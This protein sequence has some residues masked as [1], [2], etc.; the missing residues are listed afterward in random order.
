MKDCNLFSLCTH[1]EWPQPRKY[2]SS[3]AAKQEKKSNIMYRGDYGRTCLQQA[4]C[5]GAPD[6]IIKTMI[7]IG[8]KELV[9]K[10]DND[11]RTA[12]HSACMNGASYDIIKMLIEVGGR[13]LVLAEDD[14]GDT[15]LHYLC[16]SIEED[17]DAAEDQILMQVAF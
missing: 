6:D 11:E 5:R 17:N 7:D 16:W 2:L 4:C 8:G 3:D 13:D 9:M 10:I 15:A 14:D 12:L 1:K